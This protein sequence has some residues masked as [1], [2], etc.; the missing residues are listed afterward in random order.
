MQ[1]FHQLNKVQMES[2]EYDRPW[3][4]PY[5]TRM[6]N[7]IVRRRGN[8]EY[9]S[10]LEG[11]CDWRGEQPSYEDVEIKFFDESQNRCMNLIRL[12]DMGLQYIDS[13]VCME[14][15]STPKVALKR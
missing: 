2:G 14:R 5:F 8:I 12:A 13:Y 1:E 9:Y 4:V 11:E 6:F 3:R 10:Q 15:H 7:R